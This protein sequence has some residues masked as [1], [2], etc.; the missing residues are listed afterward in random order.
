[1]TAS[2]SRNLARSSVDA[3]QWQRILAERLPPYR[4]LLHNDD[5]HSMEY[6][7]RSLCRVVPALSGTEALAIMYQAH[8]SGVSVVTVCPKELAEHYQD[9]LRSCGLISTIEPDC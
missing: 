5:D 7:V 3:K 2:A 1:M 4:V 6:V 8:V 9:G